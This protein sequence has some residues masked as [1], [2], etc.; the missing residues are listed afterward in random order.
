MND[1]LSYSL[2][3]KGEALIFLHGFLGDRT[4][5]D[6]FVEH[7]QSKFLIVT[8]DLPGHGNSPINQDIIEMKDSARLVA[9]VLQKENIGSAHL[10]G[11]SMGG[12]VCLAFAQL[13][14][15]KIKSVTL[16]NSTARADSEQKQVDRLKAVQVFDL[17]P[18][19]FINEAIRN[20]FYIRNLVRFDKEVE[21][22]V[23]IAQKT[24]IKGAQSSLKGMRLREDLV[25]WLGTQSFPKLYIAGKHDTTILYETIKEQIP[26]TGA[27]LKT[28]NNS[29][30][31]GFIEEEI[32]CIKAIEDFLTN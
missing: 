10:I 27:K 20:L 3:G 28:L 12:Y 31:M 4:I 23:A 25:D 30:H 9:K 29:G 19:V 21:S 2:A 17:R 22:L 8:I 6:N 7:F 26:I 11:H 18:S 16:F 32:I 1:D 15:D 13:F 24:T 14:P 5:W